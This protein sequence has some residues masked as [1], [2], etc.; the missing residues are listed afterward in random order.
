MLIWLRS[1]KG[2]VVILQWLLVAAVAVLGLTTGAWRVSPTVF[3]SLVALTSLGNVALM[4]MPLQ[5]FYQPTQWMN[6]FIAD[7]VFVGA[8]IYSMRGFDTELYLPYFLIVLVAAL[9][10]SLARALAIAVAVSFLYMFL[11]WREGSAQSL[12]DSAY[13]I[14]LPFFLVIALFTGYLANAAR[15][16]SE[17][18]MSSRILSE[19]V[20]SL[21]QLAS[22]IAHEVRNP[23]TAI[24]TGLEV[25]MRRLPREGEERVIVEEALAQVGRVRRMVQETL[26]LARPLNLK[27][28]WLDLNAAL[29]RTVRDEAGSRT[30]GRVV[31][32]KRIAPQPLML[33][34][35]SVL[36][37]QAMHNVV[38][39]AMEAM[40]QGGTLTVGTAALS[41]RGQE[42]VL[43]RISDSGGGIPAHQLERLFQP[44]YT[45]K[46]QGTG[47]GLSLARKYLR[48]HGGELTVDSVAGVGTRVAL[49]LPVA[50]SVPEMP[51]AKAPAGS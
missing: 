20:R 15:L 42:Q 33:W 43:A 40:P 36:I 50:G 28:G 45:T 13:L 14:R 27:P 2:I 18:Q 22:G 3:W 31:I 46:P 32:V 9:T 35:D 26:D 12:L 8:A 51:S 29:E 24:G 48:A 19:Q 25:L 41:V 37:E 6:L 44:F 30:D 7:T 17:A 49:F 38:R 5:Y 11:V 10:R 39:N 1:R 4:R 21:Q 34:G 16:Q 47:L 23:L